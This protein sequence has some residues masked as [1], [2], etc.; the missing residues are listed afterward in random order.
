MGKGSYY[1]GAGYV[2]L[3]TDLIPDLLPFEDGLMMPSQLL[4]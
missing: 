1:W 2:V 4:L 3:P